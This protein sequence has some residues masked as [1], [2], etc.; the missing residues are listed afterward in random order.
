MVLIQGPKDPV[1]P[2]P[3]YLL[4]NLTLT[5]LCKN[6]NL[7]HS[8]EDITLVNVDASSIWEGKTCWAP[9]EASKKVK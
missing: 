8:F 4:R 7:T 1:L 6:A 3:K 5:R 2:A 9:L